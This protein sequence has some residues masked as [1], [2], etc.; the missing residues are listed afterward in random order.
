MLYFSEYYNGTWQTA[1]TSDV[2]NPCSLG[3]WP[4]SYG[5]FDR[6][7]LFLRPW[8][9]ADPADDSLYV[10]VTIRSAIPLHSSARRLAGAL[11]CTTPTAPRIHGPTSPLSPHRSC[12]CPEGSALSKVRMIRQPVLDGG[13]LLLADINSSSSVVPIVTGGLPQDIATAQANVPD[14]SLMPFFFGDSR[15]VFYVTCGSIPISITGPNSGFGSSPSLARTTTG[16]AS[17]IPPIVARRGPAQPDAPAEVTVGLVSTSAARRAVAADGLRTVIG[18]GTAIT[19]QGRS[20][21][22]TGSA[23]A[24]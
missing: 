11:C 13:L 19:F 24:Q 12:P 9:A 16:A 23:P 3:T 21:G 17:T 18:G 4:Q 8:S 2:G 22:V 6:S 1:K 7:L 10:E 5:P 20:I 14:Q 15:S